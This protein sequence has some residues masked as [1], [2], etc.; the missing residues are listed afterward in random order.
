MSHLPALA[1]APLVIATL[2]SIQALVVKVVSAGA[3]SHL[4]RLVLCGTNHHVST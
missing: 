3:R 4:D 2:E 1:G